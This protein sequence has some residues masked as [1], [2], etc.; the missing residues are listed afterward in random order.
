MVLVEGAWPG[1]RGRGVTWPRPG[2][3]RGVRRFGSRSGADPAVPRRAWR[4]RCGAGAERAWSCG[5]RRR[6]GC[7]AGSFCSRV[8]PSGRRAPTWTRRPSQ[9]RLGRAGPGRGG[10]GGSGEASA[11]RARGGAGRVRG[12]PRASGWGS[13]PPGVRGGLRGLGGPRAVGGS[14]PGPVPSVR[15]AGV[16]R[17]GLSGGAAL[18]ALRERYRQRR[19]GGGAPRG[20]VGPGGAEGSERDPT[21]APR[22]ESRPSGGRCVGT[23]GSGGSG[24]GQ[25]GAERLRAPPGGRRNGE[26][27]SRTERRAEPPR[28]AVGGGGSGEV[29]RRAGPDPFRA[30]RGRCGALRCR[31]E[32]P[33]RLGK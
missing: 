30:L 13:G 31:L 12:F 29:G 14:E 25:R 26:S 22:R 27:R 9:V 19:A 8:G 15:P 10:G 18:E 33:G 32:P 21:G 4:P 28:I 1:Q 24:G 17:A 2:R 3:Q 7:C 23:E 11:E 6:C 5:R 16:P 20:A